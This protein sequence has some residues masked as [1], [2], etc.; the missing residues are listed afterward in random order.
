MFRNLQSQLSKTTPKR[1]MRKAFTLIELIIVIFLI[2]VLVVV[3][4]VAILAVFGNTKGKATEANLT[5]IGSGVLNLL[6]S[7]PQIY[8]CLLG[9]GQGPFPAEAVSRFSIGTKL[10]SSLPSDK[11][12]HGRRSGFLVLAIS[13]TRD[14]MT[15]NGVTA[16]WEGTMSRE[17]SRSLTNTDHEFADAKYPVFLD[18]WGNPITFR[19]DPD[20]NATAKDGAL[21]IQLVSAGEDGDYSTEED[22]FYW[23]AANNKTWKGENRP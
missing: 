3:L 18:G 6:D 11:E 17:S 7:N 20:P 8:Y 23:S 21:A 4:I 10:D 5:N 14:A 9:T 2:I 15:E 13:P 16:G 19:L 1:G 12:T 22:N